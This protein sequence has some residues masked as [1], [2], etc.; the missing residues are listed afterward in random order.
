MELV[1]S[2][3]IKQTQVQPYWLSV[4]RV[5][6][7]DVFDFK[8]KEKASGGRKAAGK[9]AAILVQNLNARCLL[10]TIVNLT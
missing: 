6:F 9:P 2:T 8:L 3:V 7:W 1:W 10:S 5:V 4:V